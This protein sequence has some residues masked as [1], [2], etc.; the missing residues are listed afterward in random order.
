MAGRIDALI[1]KMF[2]LL[3]AKSLAEIAEGLGISIAYVN[4]L[5][6]ILRK[7]PEYYGWTV[8]HV[9]RGI[10]V[11]QDDRFHAVM[12]QRD[13]TWEIDEDAHADARLGAVS[14]VSSIITQQTNERAAFGALM[15]HTRSRNLRAEYADLM[16]DFG[17][18]S[19]KLTKVLDTLR[20][21]TDG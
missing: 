8:P 17:Y 7:N 21:G 14:T 13:G 2:D 18:M 5:L 11:N 16:E 12:V 19:R 15:Q 3:P 20:N 1:D 9:Q 4:T 10:N 6:A